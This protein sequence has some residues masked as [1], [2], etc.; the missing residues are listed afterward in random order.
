MISGER[1]TK[2]KGGK[3]S[4]K[5]YYLLMDDCTP[6]G[7]CTKLETALDCLSNYAGEKNAKWLSRDCYRYKDEK[8]V[9]FIT[10]KAVKRLK[11]Y[12]KAV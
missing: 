10:L 4:K 9:H 3:V 2:E 6:V 1:K 8:G 7:I 12:E 11:I 5:D